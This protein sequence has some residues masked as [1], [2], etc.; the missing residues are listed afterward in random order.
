M[1]KLKQNWKP[2][3]KK[4]MIC[5]VL[6]DSKIVVNLLTENWLFFR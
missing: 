3:Y 6:F 4:M 2:K 1:P 5:L